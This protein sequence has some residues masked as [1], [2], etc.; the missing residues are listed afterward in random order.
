MIYTVTFN[1]LNGG[2]ITFLR[3]INLLTTPKKITTDFLYILFILRGRHSHEI[4][5]F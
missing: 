4:Y 2:F 5:L 1:L 3:L